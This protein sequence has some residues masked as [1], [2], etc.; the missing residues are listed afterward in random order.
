MDL[1]QVGSRVNPAC[2]ANKSRKKFETLTDSVHARIVR[3]PYFRSQHMSLCLLVEVDK[4]KAYV[5]PSIF[6]NNRSQ[7][8]PCF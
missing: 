1:L 2:L 5:L 3:L 8:S 6:R 4:P 7:K